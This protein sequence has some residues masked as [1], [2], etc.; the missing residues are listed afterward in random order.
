MNM[1]VHLM[2]NQGSFVNSIFSSIFIITFAPITFFAFARLFETLRHKR[3]IVDTPYSKID[4]APQDFVKIKGK[5]YP[6]DD[7]EIIL[8]PLTQRPCCWY[9]YSVEQIPIYKNDRFERLEEKTSINLFRITDETGES[10]IYPDGAELTTKKKGS[11]RSRGFDQLLIMA[12]PILMNRLKKRMKPKYSYQFTEN[13]LD[14]GGEI[15]VLG[16]LQH[17]STGRNPINEY[18]DQVIN[19]DNAIAIEQWKKLKKSKN[20]VSFISRFQLE[21]RPYIISDLDLYHFVR[22]CQKNIWFSGLCFFLCG[23][24]TIFSIYQCLAP[25][26]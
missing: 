1:S 4:S 14:I 16:Y 17:Y 8:S 10:I 2:F 25:I 3:M 15:T 18:E 13:R 19:H 9:N 20:N 12:E 23:A 26:L 6:I 11:W 22:D 5:A 24:I 7:T 21:G